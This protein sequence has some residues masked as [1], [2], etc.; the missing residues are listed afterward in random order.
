MKMNS[1]RVAP[2]VSGPP[3]A[4]R[5]ET[6]PGYLTSSFELRAG[7]EVSA[8]ALSQL[9][10]EVMRELLRLQGS[11]DGSAPALAA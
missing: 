5:G 11:W 7:L 3:L 6:A 10:A 8:V 4:L 2:S 9:P 1:M